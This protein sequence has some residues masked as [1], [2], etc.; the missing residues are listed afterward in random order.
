MRRASLAAGLVAATA[1]AYTVATAQDTRSSSRTEISWLLTSAP[2]DTVTRERGNCASGRE[3]ASVRQQRNAGFRGV[4]D[5]ADSCAAVL[6]RLGRDGV[7]G[8]V[9]DP[10]TNVPTPAVAF[11]TGFVTAFRRAE[12]LP[13]ELPGLAAIKPVVERCLAQAETNTKLCFSVGYTYGLR[14]ANG[15]MPVG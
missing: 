8:F 4:P 10:R 3:P 15:E 13:A 14:A 11:D 2:Q 12:A 7:L 6:T 5:A 9:T 1:L